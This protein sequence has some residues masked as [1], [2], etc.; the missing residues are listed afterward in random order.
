MVVVVSPPPSRLVVQSNVVEEY[1][2]LICV[3]PD[4]GATRGGE[5]RVTINAGCVL[6][7][8]ASTTPG[9][10]LLFRKDLTHEG[11]PVTAGSK[12]IVSVNVWAMRRVIAA[13]PLVHVRFAGSTLLP[14][15]DASIATGAAGPLT[16]DR[17]AANATLKDIAESR[18][19]VISASV[20]ED[21]PD[22]SI[23]EVTVSSAFTRAIRVPSCAAVPTRGRN[24]LREQSFPS[25][26]ER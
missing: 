26:R 17:T 24:S 3:T 4:G 18:S 25:G 13:A 10:A 22:V 21:F 16:G 1:T 9:S 5:T 11:L 12:E 7:S 6:T 15:H 23:R 20:L 19:F 14:A 8:R 2:L